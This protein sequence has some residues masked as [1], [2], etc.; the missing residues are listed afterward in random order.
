[1]PIDIE[2]LSLEELLDLNRRIMRDNM[3]RDSPE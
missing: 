1:M 3:K 2:K